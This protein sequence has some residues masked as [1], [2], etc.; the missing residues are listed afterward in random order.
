MPQQEKRGL[1]PCLFKNGSWFVSWKIF[2]NYQ[3]NDYYVFHLKFQF[4]S[5]NESER[6]GMEKY[7]K[8]GFLLLIFSDVF[9]VDEQ[10]HFVENRFR[11]QTDKQLLDAEGSV[12]WGWFLFLLRVVSKISVD[13]LFMRVMGYLVE[14]LPTKWIAGT[15]WNVI[16]PDAMEDGKLGKLDWFPENSS[17]KDC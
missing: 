17:P 3:E 12:E 5:L 16:L 15:D 11:E 8:L 4:C 1:K 10:T 2:P 9:Q 14:N 7:C 6:T 13:W